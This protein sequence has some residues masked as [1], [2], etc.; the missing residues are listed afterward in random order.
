MDTMGQGQ[1]VR[2]WE[3]LQLDDIRRIPNSHLTVAAEVATTVATQVTPSTLTV[4]LWMTSGGAP[5][6]WLQ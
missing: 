5:G 1:T 6:E 3:V 4:V 2:N